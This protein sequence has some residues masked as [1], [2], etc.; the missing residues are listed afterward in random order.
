M[1]HYYLGRYAKGVLPVAW[2]TSGAPV[3]LLRPFGF[4]TIY[5]ENHSALCAAQKMGGGLCLVAEER[6]YSKDL[7]S[8]AKIDLGVFFSGRTPVGRLPKPDLL[9]ASNNICGTVLYWYRVLSKEYS[10]PLIVFDTP[11]NYGPLRQEDL[12]YM[13][14][15]IEEIIEELQRIS[16]REFRMERLIET[17]RL[18]KATCELWQEILNTMKETPAPATI[19]DIFSHMLPIVSL[20]GLRSAHSYYQILYGEL[21]QR[22]RDKVSPLS[23]ER[24]RLLWDNIAIWYK[25]RDLSELMMR[26]KAN[27]VGAT[28]TNAWAETIV[29]MDPTKPFE[30]LAKAY[31]LVILNNNLY[32]RLELI[33]KLAAEFNVNGPAR[34]CADAGRCRRAAA[35]PAFGRHRARHFGASAARRFP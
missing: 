2:V 7:C 4:Y 13:L 21:F 24:I 6:G 29:H 3:E 33:R 26:H 25:M 5:P 14:D 28:Y 11:F 34:R 10:I 8:Y 22:V 12:D 19:F 27:L 1:S 17:M 18:S 15:Q 35:W 20:R 16:K 30:S 9:F 31:S 32:H 23:E